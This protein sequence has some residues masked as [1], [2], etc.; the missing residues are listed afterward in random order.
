LRKSLY[1]KNAID[2][3]EFAKMRNKKPEERLSQNKK[4]GSGAAI[5]AALMKGQPLSKRE[6]IQKAAI[7]DSTFSRMEP[8][9]LREDLIKVIG[10]KYYLFN[11]E[12]DEVL[13]EIFKK[14]M[15]E[16]RK[17]VQIEEVADLA[18]RSPESIIDN[19]YKIAKKYDVHFYYPNYV[20][21]LYN[22]KYLK[23]S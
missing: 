21:N 15:S 12:G 18:G 11:F 8:L 14:F 7:D 17:L 16:G 19:A 4:L 22:K 5:M 1:C 23:I 2:K 3:P 13:E 9:L 10:D 20:N 6:L